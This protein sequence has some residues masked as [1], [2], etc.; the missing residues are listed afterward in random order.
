MTK[1]YRKLYLKYKSKYL[2]L[3]QFGGNDIIEILS[4]SSKDNITGLLGNIYDKLAIKTEDFYN[5][6][7]LDRLTD[8]GYFNDELLSNFIAANYHYNQIIKTKIKLLDPTKETSEYYGNLDIIIQICELMY[9]NIIK[10]ISINNHTIMLVPGD[11]PIYF[12]FIIKILHPEIMTDSRITIVEF[13]ISSVGFRMKL[14]PVD[15]N[16]YFENLLEKVIGVEKLNQDH[17]FMLMDYYESGDSAD[18]IKSMIRCTY[19]KKSYFHNTNTVKI[20]DLDIRQYF[21]YSE[22][23]ETKDL[24]KYFRVKNKIITE[25]KKPWERVK[26]KTRFNYLNPRIPDN[27]PEEYPE[28]LKLNKFKSKLLH[29][30]V[31]DSERRCQYKLPIVNGNEYAELAKTSDLTMKQYYESIQ[32]KPFNYKLC[33]MLS[34]L[35][36]IYIKFNTQLKEKTVPILG[37]IKEK[38]H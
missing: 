22:D 19:A 34:M 20:T 27:F 28:N 31:D 9:Q 18:Y 7:E 14:N 16:P 25:G 33:N 24:E 17:N 15:G 26:N 3:K 36:Y 21:L 23:W 6:G 38:T 29:Y 8:S 30:F 4:S 13:P 32:T 11:S 5:I 37:I 35:F 12:L 2:N 1:D 10:H